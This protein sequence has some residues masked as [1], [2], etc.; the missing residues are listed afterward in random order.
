[1]DIVMDRQLSLAY[2]Q[3][4]RGYNNTQNYGYKDCSPNLPYL[5]SW[6]D[7]AARATDKKYSDGNGGF[8]YLPVYELTTANFDCW[9]AVHSEKIRLPRWVPYSQYVALNGYDVRPSVQSVDEMDAL[10][11]GI[12]CCVN[13]RYMQD[14][15]G[16]SIYFD[17]DSYKAVA[18]DG[19]PMREDYVDIMSVSGRQITSV[20]EA[21]IVSRIWK[22]C[23][24]RMWAMMHG[25]SGDD[26]D[27]VDFAIHSFTEDR[28]ATCMAVFTEWL[29]RILPPHVMSMICVTIGA[30]YGEN[31]WNNSVCR[32][33]IDADA[34]T[35]NEGIRRRMYDLIGITNGIPTQI[36]I[37]KDG[38][39]EIEDWEQTLIS[40]LSENSYP[41]YYTILYDLIRK[42]EL[43]LPVET[44]GQFGVVLLADYEILRLC[45]LFE[46]YLANARDRQ[47][48]YNANVC[49]Y[50]IALRLFEGY[51]IEP[52]A[53]HI[54]LNTMENDLAQASR[55][56]VGSI[57]FANY[58]ALLEIYCRTSDAQLR[59]T[60]F[61]TLSGQFEADGELFLRNPIVVAQKELFRAQELLLAERYIYDGRARNLSSEEYHELVEMHK[62]ADDDGDRELCEKLE[63]VLS[64]CLHFA[65]SDDSPLKIAE[66]FGIN[67]VIRELVRNTVSDYYK[68]AR[69]RLLTHQYEEL[70]A[71][72]EDYYG[73]MDDGARTKTDELL[74]CQFAFEDSPVVPAQLLYNEGMTQLWNRYLV[75]ECASVK[76][77][78]DDAEFK[79]WV[80][81]LSDDE[82]V[83]DSSVKIVRMLVERASKDKLNAYI[84]IA[85][86]KELKELKEALILRAL[87]EIDE[88][89]NKLEASEYEWWL[90]T[91]KAENDDGNEIAGKIFDALCRAQLKGSERSILELTQSKDAWRLLGKLVIREASVVENQSLNNERYEKW[92]GIYRA[93]CAHD[94]EVD[95]GSIQACEEL[96]STK[97]T[98]ETLLKLHHA[99]VRGELYWKA[100]ASMC[101][102]QLE[103]TGRMKVTVFRQWL[104]YL[105]EAE[106]AEQDVAG[107]IRSMLSTSLTL[108]SDD[109]DVNACE[110]L[111]REDYKD[112]QL[113]QT[114]IREEFDRLGQARRIRDLATLKHWLRNYRY[115]NRCGNTF[116]DDISSFICSSAMVDGHYIL[117]TVLEAEC[118]NMEECI[119]AKEKE[120]TQDY[121]EEEYRYRLKR[122][123]SDRFSDLYRDLLSGNRYNHTKAL[124]VLFTYWEENPIT[125]SKERSA[126]MLM[127]ALLDDTGRIE[128]SVMERLRRMTET[129]AMRNILSSDQDLLLRVVNEG[130][131]LNLKVHELNPFTNLITGGSIDVLAERVKQEFADAMVTGREYNCSDLL[132]HYKGTI[133]KETAGSILTKVN[134]IV[135]GRSISSGI[136]KR[137]ID[138]LAET[139]IPEP[140]ATD[141]LCSLIRE[142]A[143]QIDMS[144]LADYAD[145][146]DASCREKMTAS[147]AHWL[148]ESPTQADGTLDDIIAFAVKLPA[149]NRERVDDELYKGVVA[150][151]SGE[152]NC[153][154]ARPDTYDRI[155]DFWQESKG[156]E[157]VQVRHPLLNG[158]AAL[159]DIRNDYLSKCLD[160]GPVRI[161]AR[162]T[163]LI[164][165]AAVLE[166]KLLNEAIHAASS[167]L[168]LAERLKKLEWLDEAAF[169]VCRQDD[170]VFASFRKVI[171]NSI[172]YKSEEARRSGD[173]TYELTALCEI[174]D[175]MNQLETLAAVRSALADALKEQVLSRAKGMFASCV[176][177]YNRDTDGRA[178]NAAMDR[179]GALLKSAGA[180]NKCAVS[181]ATVDWCRLYAS[182]VRE[183]RLDA[184]AIHQIYSERSDLEMLKKFAL[185]VYEN[186]LSR[187]DAVD[188]S[189]AY[190]LLTAAKLLNMSDLWTQ[191]LSMAIRLPEGKALWAANKDTEIV[192]DVIFVYGLLKEIG[193]DVATEN[194]LSDYCLRDRHF[195]DF[196]TK[197]HN[198]ELEKILQKGNISGEKKKGGLFGLFKR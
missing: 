38:E 8:Y 30:S 109:G 35:Q 113:R 192:M 172:A 34:E 141:M 131:R 120:C 186:D 59:N 84:E 29:A 90:D 130:I 110:L 146:R 19:E 4:L 135:N 28:M 27:H 3:Y 175:E 12:G 67:S 61:E 72:R 20:Q 119:L 9:C 115:M 44:C 151:L 18:L 112:D 195:S 198:R 91:W 185:R 25:E 106:D 145:A 99:G 56:F 111:D 174:G 154:S 104:C 98:W 73:Q 188:A 169:N 127:K 40:C 43:S 101:N 82:I 157:F 64:Q 129:S 140:Y 70:V 155:C 167:P 162:Y 87:R 54:L 74:T 137:A 180:D 103:K 2:G 37:P 196:A 89:G 187:R 33:M 147:L 53:V 114:M 156:A 88:K 143:G 42:G 121:T 182:M 148:Q 150:L 134:I 41:K 152:V 79:T 197:Q 60:L 170:E 52:E 57:D 123:F 149:E 58:M 177:L 163:K 126:G 160:A 23:W 13:P 81:R 14:V 47:D 117:E 78:M 165:A 136:L 139:H 51:G 97:I 80:Q 173:K 133:D 36:D 16:Q 26:V 125:S 69:G 138:M 153:E 144:F 77:Q 62:A 179:L 132:G 116:A 124:E 164:S 68:R 191:Y 83:K 159:E 6:C 75:E 32:I 17:D 45:T 39:P 189:V 65:D 49:R 15:K 86:S 76:G 168:D 5:I 193:D 71:L 95:P 171:E 55:V 118:D 96:L 100:M 183:N 166:T 142:C 128:L 102:N 105:K 1:M 107:A 176:A 108:S 22:F 85:R 10:R 184:S 7:K 31:K 63:A 48:F 92:V 50:N 11:R 158:S 161:D 66:E 181:G 190:A 178:F 46:K 122:Y 21:R 93:L 94:E 194:S 24:D